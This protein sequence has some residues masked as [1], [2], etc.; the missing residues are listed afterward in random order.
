MSLKIANFWC[1]HCVKYVGKASESK[2]FTQYFFNVQKKLWCGSIERRKKIVNWLACYIECCDCFQLTSIAIPILRD[3]KHKFFFVDRS[4]NSFC[5]SESFLF[6]FFF[7]VVDCLLS[8]WTAHI[9]IHFSTSFFCLL[10]LLLFLAFFACNDL[11]LFFFLVSSTTFT[12]FYCRFISSALFLCVSFARSFN[13]IF[14]TSFRFFFFFLMPFYSR[15][16]FFS[17][18]V[19]VETFFPLFFLIVT[20]RRAFNEWMWTQRTFFSVT[21]F[22]PTNRHYLCVEFWFQPSKKN[23]IHS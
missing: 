21:S 11:L 4:D 19:Y 7:I 18:N 17:S 20:L 14:F 10:K 6:S 23:T 22:L 3:F 13:D 8:C 1:L 2:N 16:S 5:S 9:L 12:H 15:S